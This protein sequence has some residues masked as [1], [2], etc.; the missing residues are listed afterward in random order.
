MMRN[1]TPINDEDV[2]PFQSFLLLILA[3]AAG[4]FLALVVL[5]QLLPGMLSSTAGTAPKAFWYLSR[6]SAFAAY[7]LLWLS[8][9]FGLSIT[10]RMAQVW[11]GGPAAFELHQHVSL[12]AIAFS[13]FHALIL[14]GDQFINTTLGGVL[15]PFAMSTY[16]P[17][18]VGLGQLGLYISLLVTLTF[19]AR[20]RLGN[21]RWRAI[22]LTS[23]AAFFLV[24]AHGLL[25]GTDATTAWALSIYGV[26]GISVFFLTVYRVLAAINKPAPHAHSRGGV[27]HL[28]P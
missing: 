18:W 3:T 25:S 24:M 13:L 28:Q 2:V 10:N 27:S 26:T 20:K 6:S 15:I 17:L 16:R 9:A 5:P 11:P 12:L 23:Y 19:Y 4:A 21:Q 8:M 7:L 22:H 1:P 14:I